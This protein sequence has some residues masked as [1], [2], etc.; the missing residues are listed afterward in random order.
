MAS[1]E[2]MNEIRQM[3]ATGRLDAYASSLKLITTLSGSILNFGSW[4]I[5]PD[6]DSAAQLCIEV[7]QARDFPEVLAFASEGFI[8]A[9]A[10]M[11]PGSPDVDMWRYERVSD[12]LLRFR[13]KRDF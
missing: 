8:N 2:R 7:T 11:A 9:M 12:D 3:D 4:K 5:A 13:M 10:R 1:V 6:P